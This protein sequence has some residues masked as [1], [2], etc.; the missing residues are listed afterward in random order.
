MN[1]TKHYYDYETVYKVEAYCVLDALN[2]DML[3]MIYKYRVIDINAS[4]EVFGQ[5]PN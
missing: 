1:L 2:V 5:I 3:K 4:S